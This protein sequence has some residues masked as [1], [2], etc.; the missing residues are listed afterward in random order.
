MLLQFKE[1][2]NGKNGNAN[3]G[4]YMNIPGQTG[5][6]LLGAALWEKDGT[7][8]VG[9]LTAWHTHGHMATWPHGTWQTELREPP[10]SPPKVAKPA[11]NWREEAD[12]ATHKMTFLVAENDCNTFFVNVAFY[13]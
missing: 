4:K 12:E 1:P 9:A 11:T 3:L 5:R 10:A 2:G 6:V 7:G 8:N 13:V